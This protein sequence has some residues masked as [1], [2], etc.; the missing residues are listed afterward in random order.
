MLLLATITETGGEDLTATV[1]GD[2]CKVEANLWFLMIF[3]NPAFYPHYRVWISLAPLLRRMEGGDSPHAMLMVDG[4][5]AGLPPRDLSK[6][7]SPVSPPPPRLLNTSFRQGT[8][9]TFLT[10]HLLA[11]MTQRNM[12]CRLSKYGNY[13][14][15]PVN[16]AVSLL[17][18]M[19]WMSK[20][21]LKKYQ[22]F[23]KGGGTCQ[24]SRCNGLTQQR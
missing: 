18:M 17:E 1:D 20:K 8:A 5:S 11:L 10:F 2:P 22:T 3:T 14:L 16:S 21:N 6:P 13:R 24:T 7:Y 19:W 15:C 4:P 9:A 12:N 23:A